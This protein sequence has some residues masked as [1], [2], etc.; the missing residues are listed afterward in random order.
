MWR[1][2]F[3]DSV[4]PP[5][6]VH[7]TERRNSAFGADACSSEDEDAIMGRNGEHE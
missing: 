3:L 4:I 6:T 2:D 7:A 5:E 1:G